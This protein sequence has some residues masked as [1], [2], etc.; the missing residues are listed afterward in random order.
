MHKEEVL[1][2]IARL[3]GG[4]GDKSMKAAVSSERTE[5]N[6]GNLA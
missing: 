2:L 4:R 1:V 6:I 5:M 3:Q